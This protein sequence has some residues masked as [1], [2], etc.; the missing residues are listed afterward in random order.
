MIKDFLRERLRANSTCP[1]CKGDAFSDPELVSSADGYSDGAYITPIE[2]YR[3]NRY[4]FV[5]KDIDQLIELSAHDL[6]KLSTFVVAHSLRRKDRI[7]L[8]TFEDINPR[9]DHRDPVLVSGAIDRFPSLLT[10]L[11]DE[12]L[13]NLS[14]LAPEFG[15]GITLH[16]YYDHRVVYA[17]SE[18]AMI[19]F[20]GQLVHDGL[21]FVS[22]VEN[23]EGKYVKKSITEHVI[24]D[25][26]LTPKGWSHVAELQRAPLAAK[27]NQAFV[28]MW[29]D[30]SMKEVYEEAISRG[31]EQ[32]GYDPVLFN[33][34][35]HIGKIDDEIIAEIRKS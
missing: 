26:M 5:T 6:F 8:L 13:I 2:C 27:P 35:D 29:F 28:A 22:G 34:K 31:I 4:D 11:L 23:R 25:A 3:C 17:D 14:F 9:D 1:L 21:I 30:P 12:S 10:T 33:R 16:L 18:A 19:F 32:A 15:K 7:A 24:P 20:L